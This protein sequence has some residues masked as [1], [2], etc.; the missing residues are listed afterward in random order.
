[1]GSLVTEG[2]LFVASIVAISH[3]FPEVVAEYHSLLAAFTTINILFFIAAITVTQ[4]RANSVL[5]HFR[6]YDR[7]GKSPITVVVLSQLLPLFVSIPIGKEVF[8]R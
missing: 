5:E 1:M 7:V 2:C 8:N 4:A 6:K 3:Y